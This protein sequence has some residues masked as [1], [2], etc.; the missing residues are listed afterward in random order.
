MSFA[1]LKDN[2]NYL[3]FFNNKTTYLQAVLKGFSIANV[4]D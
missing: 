4:M 3:G 1:D 2:E